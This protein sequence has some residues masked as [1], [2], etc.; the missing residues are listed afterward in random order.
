MTRCPVAAPLMLLQYCHAS[1]YRAP[2]PGRHRPVLRYLF[3]QQLIYRSCLLHT[4]RGLHAILGQS[5]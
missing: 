5:V 1:T 2:K 4:D 3:R